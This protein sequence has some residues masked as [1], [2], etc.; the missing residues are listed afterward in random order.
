L[1]EAAAGAVVGGL[2]DAGVDPAAIQAGET[3][4]GQIGKLVSAN[5]IS[6]V[7]VPA[8]ALEIFCDR[9]QGKAGVAGRGGGL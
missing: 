5:I 9:G 7:K 4:P 3:G 1:D 8:M 2:L 6:R